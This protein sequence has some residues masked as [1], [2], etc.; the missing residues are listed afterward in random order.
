MRTYGSSLLN[1]E[2]I[3]YIGKFLRASFI[4]FCLYIVTQAQVEAATELR[5]IHR[6]AELSEHL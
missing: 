2:K 4:A 5:H 1:A 6:E 3:F